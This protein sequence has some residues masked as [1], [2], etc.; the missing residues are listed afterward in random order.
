MACNYDIF[1][2]KKRTIQS[3]ASYWL[4][5]DVVL[6]SFSFA[7]FVSQIGKSSKFVCARCSKSSST[8]EAAEPSAFGALLVLL[9]LSYGALKWIRS[10]FLDE[11]SGQAEREVGSK[12]VLRHTSLM[13]ISLLACQVDLL[14]P[15]IYFY[16]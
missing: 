5:T 16:A 15:R 2:S 14:A 7:D 12:V 8:S 6:F 13:D 1:I 4:C 11:P 3:I 10:T 9:W